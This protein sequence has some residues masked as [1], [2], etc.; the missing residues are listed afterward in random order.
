MTHCGYQPIYS[1]KDNSNLMI[2]NVDLEGDIRIGRQVK[3]LLNLDK[4]KDKVSKYS[5]K[6]I[7]DEIKKPV[8]KNSSGNISTYKM[9]INVRAIINEGE[10]MIKDKIFKASFTYNNMEN[11]FDLSE[12]QKNIRFNLINK[13]SEE[14]LFFLNLK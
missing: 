5:L 14:I 2:G 4:Q 9:T 7:I 1:K 10:E 6:L 13:I 8:A 11:K 12:Y 3:S